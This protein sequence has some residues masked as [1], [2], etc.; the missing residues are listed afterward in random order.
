MMDAP[1][2]PLWAALLVSFLLLT[3]AVA[4]LIGSLGLVRLTTFFDR[5]HPPTLGATMGT[6]ST[7]IA[8]IICFSVLQSRPVLHE[9]L[10]GLFMMVTAPASFMML[11]RAALYRTRVERIGRLAEEADDD[12]PVGN[13]PP[14]AIP[15][16]GAPSA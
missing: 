15:D 12:V 6:G 8:S 13:E 5:V 1:E 2:L 10:I 16:V 9:V 7:L 11:T 14:A 4:T 3:G